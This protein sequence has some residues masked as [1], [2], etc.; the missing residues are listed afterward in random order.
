MNIKETFSA[1]KIARAGIIASLYAL[2]S[3]LLPFL[4]YGQ[5]QVRISEALTLLPLF[6]GEA[7]VGLTIGCLIANV[8]G[9][10]IIDMIFGTL[11]TLVA[12]VITY[13]IGKKVRSKKG[14]FWFGGLP[15]IIINALV[16]P[17]TFLAITETFSVYLLSATEILIGQTIAVYG[18]GALVYPLI[19]RIDKDIK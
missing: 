14:K 19:K 8:F 2:T 16:V 5:I 11:A 4:S 18:I 6:Y 9:N 15:P 7:V 3:I 17:L 13:L 10:G 1:K 12:S